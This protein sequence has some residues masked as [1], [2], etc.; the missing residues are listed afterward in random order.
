M[1][2]DRRDP[3]EAALDPG[4][5]R[6]LREHLGIAQR[7]RRETGECLE[8]VRV[9]LLE[10]ASL[11]PTDT[12]DTEHLVAPE[13]RSGDH[14]RETVVRRVRNR[15]R[16]LAVGAVDQGPALARGCSRQAVTG[17]KLEAH[18]RAREPVHG[19]AAEMATL[20]VEQVAI[21]GVRVEQLRELVGEPLQ[22][23][24][25]VQLAAQ[26]VSGA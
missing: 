14:V 19:D 5:T 6:A 7:Q 9:A 12:E 2:E 25:Q 22:D 21:R 16:D 20:A 26:D 10:P 4:L 8:N 15:R 24:R 13:H 1:P 3:V 18:Q 11:A 17:R 23:D